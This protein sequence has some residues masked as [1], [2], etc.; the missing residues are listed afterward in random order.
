M[1]YI[2]AVS[3]FIICL[4]KLLKVVM[5]KQTVFAFLEFSLSFLFL[6]VVI[7]KKVLPT[8]KI[9]NKTYFSSFF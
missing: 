4:L 6:F 2:N 9:K 3:Q 8:L 1:S 7:L 5:A